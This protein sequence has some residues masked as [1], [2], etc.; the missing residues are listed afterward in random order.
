MKSLDVAELSKYRLQIPGQVDEVNIGHCQND[1]K[2]KHVEQVTPGKLHTV[3]LF[4]VQKNCGDL[5]DVDVKNHPTAVHD[6]KALQSP[7]LPID[8]NLRFVVWIEIN[9]W[10]FQRENYHPKEQVVQ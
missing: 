1:E 3:K 6:A 9:L 2:C 4:C 7:D 8:F 10:V 5:I